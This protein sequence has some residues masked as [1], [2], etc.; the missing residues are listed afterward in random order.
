MILEFY[1]LAALTCGSGLETKMSFVIEPPKSGSQ[2]SLVP[3]PV[4]ALP[5]E[6]LERTTIENLLRC[7]LCAQV[8]QVP[9]LMCENGHTTCEPCST[10]SPIC[11]YCDGGLTKMRNVF[12]E[13][14]LQQFRGPCKFAIQGCPLILGGPAELHGHLERCFYRLTQMNMVLS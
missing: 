9:I 1:E 8:P 3:V 13:K 4:P 7:P 12:A 14:L 6:S 2:P 5:V 10:K 11:P